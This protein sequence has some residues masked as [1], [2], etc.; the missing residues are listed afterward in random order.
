MAGLKTPEGLENVT[1]PV[2]LEPVTVAVQVVTEPAANTDGEQATVTEVCARGLTV[3]TNVPELP[4][5]L[6]SPP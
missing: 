1:V 3:R 2:G 4:A 6:E 5:L